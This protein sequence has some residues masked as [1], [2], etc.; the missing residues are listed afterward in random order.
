MRIAVKDRYLKT[1]QLQKQAHIDL[2][3]YFQKQIADARRAEEEPYQW[4]EAQEWECLKTCLVDK[5]VFDYLLKRKDRSEILAYWLDI[6]KQLDC[7]MDGEVKKLLRKWKLVKG[8]VDDARLIYGVAD[9]LRYSS[10]H[11]V[12][13]QFGELALQL[14]QETLGVKHPEYFKA[15]MLIG[16]LLIA[17]SQYDKA[18][19]LIGKLLKQ[20]EKIFGKTSLQVAELTNCLSALYF[21]ASDYVKASALTKATIEMR[22]KLLGDAHPDTVTAGNNLANIKEALS[23]F[24]DAIALHRNYLARYRQIYG[25][26]SAWYALSLNNLASSLEKVGK[27][28]E[29]VQ[30]FRQSIQ[31]YEDLLG[32][33]SSDILM[34]ISNLG[35]LLPKLGIEGEGVELCRRALHICERV[36]GENNAETARLLINIASLIYDQGERKNLIL[37]AHRISESVLGEH[38]ITAICLS[39]LASIYD[40]EDDL[41]LAEKYYLASLEMAQRIYGG[42]GYITADCMFNV[43]NFYSNNFTD[44]AN[45]ALQYYRRALEIKRI[46]VGD[47]SPHLCPIMFAIADTE[48]CLEQFEQAKKIYQEIYRIIEMNFGL[49]SI[50]IINCLARLADIDERD[51]QYQ[52]A[53]ELY[54]RAYRLSSLHYGESADLTGILSERLGRLYLTT[55]RLDQSEKYL[56]EALKITQKCHGVNSELIIK[57]LKA[58]VELGI[59]QSNTRLANKYLVQA[60]NVAKSNES[61]ELESLERIAKEVG[62]IPGK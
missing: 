47:D 38:R 57:P 42:E 61:E 21:G 9:F 18:R 40:Q 31:I 34:P 45:T 20:A 55:N 27:L 33:Y 25:V 43:G 51:K 32:P 48:E 6:Q 26:Q 44:V 13:L 4:R 22:S 49:E 3:K 10:L 35:L 39:F 24:D 59:A 60:I 37:R 5:G 53:E 30:C 46:T 29:A 16:D 52:S 58:L 54:L 19:E 56:N 50:Q 2:A 11:G 23:E 12:A 62:F 17:K 14:I 36:F 8:S 28:D 15:G 1:K 41:G 7:H